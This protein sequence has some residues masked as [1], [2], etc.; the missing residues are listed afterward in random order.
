[1]YV[2][3]PRE[4]GQRQGRPDARREAGPRRPALHPLEDSRF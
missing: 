3:D 1:M 4:Q 2:G